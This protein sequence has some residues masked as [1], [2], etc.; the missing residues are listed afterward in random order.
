MLRR[1]SPQRWEKT[2]KIISDIRYFGGRVQ[3]LCASDLDAEGLGD[4]WCYSNGEGTD[5]MGSYN[6][7]DCWVTLPLDRHRG[8]GTVETT[9]RHELVH[10]LQDATDT[11]PRTSV[12]ELPLLSSKMR[13]GDW[14]AKIC[15]EEHDRQ[16]EQAENA[17]DVIP[18]AE[19][20]A[21]SIDTWTKS[22]ED[23]TEEVK[24]RELW[25]EV[26]SCPID[27][28]SPTEI[29]DTDSREEVHTD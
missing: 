24:S 16:K 22:V 13:W 11:R 3:F 23:W 4:V 1:I 6:H 5:T 8:W 2:T 28:D 15:L 12:R 21:H 27:I 20:E 26:W 7:D 29:D 19:I 10:L 17:T 9:L 14:L 25:A 18:V